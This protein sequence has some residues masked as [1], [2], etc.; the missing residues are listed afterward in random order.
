MAG[1][2]LSGLPVA[3]YHYAAMVGGACHRWTVRGVVSAMALL[4][5]ASACSAP[6]AEP[7]DLSREAQQPPLEPDYAPCAAADADC[8]AAARQA[9]ADLAARL[10]VA[11]EGIELLLAARIT[12]RDGSLGCPKPDH[13]YTLALVPGL[14][15]KLRTAA[16][17]YRYHAREQGEP[18][19]CDRPQA[20][21]DRDAGHG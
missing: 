18:F 17:T 2:A 8:A 15:I 10:A 6:A 16:T 20:D 4:I 19:L 9:R 13:M 11:A 3:A 5:A 21:E 14:L 7:A 1:R 12:W